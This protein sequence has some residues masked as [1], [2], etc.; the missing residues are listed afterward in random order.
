MY[1]TEVQQ[2]IGFGT[3]A[4]GEC[5]APALLAALHSLMAVLFDS[6]ILGIVFSRISHPKQRARTILISDCA[7]ISRRDGDLKL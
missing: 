7:I 5:W 2:T 4:T 6:I 3:R 1:A